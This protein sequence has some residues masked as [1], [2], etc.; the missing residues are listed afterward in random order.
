MVM[1]A[2]TGVMCPQA[3]GCG[4]DP[5]W[6]GRTGSAPR[7]QGPHPHLA[8]GSGLQNGGGGG[9]RC[10]LSGPQR[11]VLGYS[12]LRKCYTQTPNV[13]FFVSK[14]RKC[15]FSLQGNQV[16]KLFTPELSRF[17]LERE[18]ALGVP[19]APEGPGDHARGRG[20]PDHGVP[21]LARL[22]LSSEPLLPAPL[23]PAG[24]APHWGTCSL[25]RR[26]NC[27]NFCVRSKIPLASYK[28]DFNS[29]AGVESGNGSRTAASGR[30]DPASPGGTFSVLCPSGGWFRAA[31]PW[32]SPSPA[33][34]RTAFPSP[35]TSPR[36]LPLS[37]D[38][39]RGPPRHRPSQPPP[40]AHAATRQPLRRLVADDP[41][42]FEEGPPGVVQSRPPL[43]S[44]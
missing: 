40:A 29:G 43:G 5:G 9:G 13:K 18:P 10:L 38:A 22:V 1:E 4:P 20:A 7:L 26:R 33:D 30:P 19:T 25:G 14:R 2:G 23:H 12:S 39:H 37:Q 8:A 6:R 32:G 41:A 44:V 36:G 15:C 21:T 31:S 42:R 11:V 24:Q 17:G 28:T 35:P 27:Q 3:K 34:V 16:F